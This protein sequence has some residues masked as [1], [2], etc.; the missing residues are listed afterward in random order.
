M[1][2]VALCFPLESL[3]LGTLGSQLGPDFTLG[4]LIRVHY[5]SVQLYKTPPLLLKDAQPGA[6]FRIKQVA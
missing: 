4:L 3:C 5:M 2:P 6:M 1:V